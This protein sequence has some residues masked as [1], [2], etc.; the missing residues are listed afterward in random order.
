VGMPTTHGSD[1]PVSSP[2]NAKNEDVE[3]QLA[4]EDSEKTVPVIN[5]LGWLDRFLAIWIL[6]AMIVGLLLGN[7]VEQTGPALQKGKFVGISIPI[8]KTQ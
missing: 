5:G 3:R 2:L 7:Y 8:G 1:V 4:P 6:H